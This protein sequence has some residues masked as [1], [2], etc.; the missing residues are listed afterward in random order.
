[1]M[2][3]DLKPPQ[4][5]VFPDPAHVLASY[6]LS[7]QYF[8][9]LAGRRVV[10]Y[11]SIEN[12]SETLH[13][14][15]EREFQNQS[16]M[17]HDETLPPEQVL[18]KNNKMSRAVKSS[19]VKST[20]NRKCQYFAAGPALHLAPSQWG[21]TEIWATGGLVTFSPTM[22]LRH[23][24][25]FDEIM[26]IIRLAPNWAAYIIPEVVQWVNSSWKIPT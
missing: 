8:A 7:P 24:D 25:K 13:R 17:P 11:P 1:M 14:R 16:V 12:D 9:S 5:D 2:M 6:G 3:T 20:A 18:F 19:T 22:I 21:L 15:I 26:N 4:V 10:V 23:P